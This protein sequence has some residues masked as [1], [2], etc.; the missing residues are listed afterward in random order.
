MLVPRP[1]SPSKPCFFKNV[2]EAPFWTP[3]PSLGVVFREESENDGPE[4]QIGFLCRASTNEGKGTG[5]AQVDCSSGGAPRQPF[6]PPGST[7]TFVFPPG[8]FF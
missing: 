8:V 1:R 2:K 6:S 5:A 4:A 3:M 7:S